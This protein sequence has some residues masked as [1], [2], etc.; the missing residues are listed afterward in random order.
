MTHRLRV[1]AALLAALLFS[2]G[3]VAPTA[4]AAPGD[5]GPPT[6]TAVQARGDAATDRFGVES[7]ATRLVQ[8]AIDPG[9]YECG[10]TAFN[11]FID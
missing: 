3:L 4:S 7:P 1:L 8:R 6:P 2:I 5:P 9:D 11:A 10:P